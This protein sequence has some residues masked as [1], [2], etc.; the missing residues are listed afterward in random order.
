LQVLVT[1]I[2]K[3]SRFRAVRHIADS[4]LV[5][6]TP[7]SRIGEASRVPSHT[8]VRSYCYRFAARV[9]GSV[10]ARVLACFAGASCSLTRAI[11]TPGA[12]GQQNAQSEPGNQCHGPN[13]IGNAAATRSE[14][15]N[16]ATPSCTNVTPKARGTPRQERRASM[17]VTNSKRAG[18]QARHERENLKRN[19]DQE[20]PLEN[21]NTVQGTTI[22]PPY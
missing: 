8:L 15:R 1:S 21:T 10:V 11:R 2:C 12:C 16:N 13:V 17:L 22:A 6:C 7:V 19:A 14:A 3:L 18:R 4:F 9:R 20:L 5:P